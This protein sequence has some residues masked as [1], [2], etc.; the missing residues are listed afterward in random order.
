MSLLFIKNCAVNMISRIS[1]LIL[2]KNSK[3]SN[4]VL[5]SML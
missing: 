5:C 1:P 3:Y 2:K 4:G